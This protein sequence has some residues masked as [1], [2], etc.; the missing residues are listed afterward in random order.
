MFENNS[1]YTRRLRGLKHFVPS[2]RN[3][4]GRKQENFFNFK[5]QRT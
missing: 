5:L 4:H 2:D 1:S 3:K